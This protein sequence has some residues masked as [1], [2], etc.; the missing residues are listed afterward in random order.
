M[1][2]PRNFGVEHRGIFR[3][4]PNIL[5]E[6]FVWKYLQQLTIFAKFQSWMYDWVLNR[7][8]DGFAQDAPREEPAIVPA[9]ACLATTSWE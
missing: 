2:F 9:V 3:P 6:A 7:P 8:L 1:H 5:N 4:Q